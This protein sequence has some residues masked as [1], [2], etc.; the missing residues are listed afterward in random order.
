MFDDAGTEEAE[1]R[2]KEFLEKVKRENEES[3]RS[4]REEEER[5]RREFMNSGSSSSNSYQQFSYPEPQSRFEEINE[6]DEKMKIERTKNQ[7]FQQQ[8]CFVEPKGQGLMTITN[9]SH[10]S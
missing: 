3:F 1:K 8:Q 10:E 7:F 5:F 2:Q 9:I 6:S 4:I